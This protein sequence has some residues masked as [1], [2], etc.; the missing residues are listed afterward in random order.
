MYVVTVKDALTIVVHVFLR[1]IYIYIYIN[2]IIKILHASLYAYYL[3]KMSC[4]HQG[5]GC[6]SD[7]Y[8]E[9]KDEMNQ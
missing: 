1:Y 6:V 8:K 2:H 9:N 3:K 4:T 5:F 7:R